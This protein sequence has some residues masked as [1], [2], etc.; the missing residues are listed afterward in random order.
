MVYK[1]NLEP[2]PEMDADVVIVEDDMEGKLRPL[3][4]DRYERKTFY[5]RPRETLVVLVNER[6]SRP[7]LR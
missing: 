2:G 5:L 3:L 1:T 4:N 6:D 7:E